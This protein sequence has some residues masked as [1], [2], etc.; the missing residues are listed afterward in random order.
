MLYRGF[1]PPI[2][3]HT[4]ILTIFPGIQPWSLPK[5][6]GWAVENGF[7]GLEVGPAVP[8]VPS[9]FAAARRSGATL[10]SLTYGRNVLAGDPA[11]RAQ[12][13]RNVL[14]RV[15]F[16]G[17]HAIPLVVLATGRAPGKSLRAN[18]PA[19]VEWLGEQVLPLARQGNVTIA[20]ENCPAVGNIATS[21]AMW[22][23]LFDIA[24]P[25]PNLTLCFDPSHLVWQFV[26]AAAA[27][28]EF[29]PKVTH[30]HVKDAV[31]DRRR[32]AHEGIDGEGWW[33]YTLPGWGELP[34]PTLIAELQRANYGGCLSIEQEDDA[35]D[36]SEGQ[37]LQSLLW[38]KRYLEQFFGPEVD[39][40]AVEAVAPER[41]AGVKPI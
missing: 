26:D 27:L 6:A 17:E 2:A 14:D 4:N 19:V 15:R 37:I 39:V 40:P 36:K 35:W 7:D 32:L 5:L 3:F 24:L 16:A 18:L 8:L 28:H 23:E 11:E 1:R 20:I 30:V 31:V 29:A 33:R 9:D 13:Q 34:W 38:S 10:F 41:V 22:H 21:P 25:A 12:H